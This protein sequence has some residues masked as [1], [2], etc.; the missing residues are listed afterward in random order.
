MSL[1]VDPIISNLIF[2]LGLLPHTFPNP[3][4]KHLPKPQKPLCLPFVSVVVPFRNEPADEI[5]LTMTSLL[6]Q[7]Y[8]HD[9]YEL[10]FVLEPEDLAGAR[11]VSRWLGEFSKQSVCARIVMSDGLSQMKA[12]ALNIA[13]GTATGRYCAFYD[14]GDQIDR[15]QIEKAIVLMEENSWD[16]AQARVLRTGRSIL[17]R[18]LLLD[19]CVWY[20]KYIP[21]LLRLCGGFPLS[22]EGLFIRKSVLDQ[23]SGFPEVLT[24]DALL[25]V[26]LT[27]AGRRFGLVD[28]TVSE[29]AP[30]SLLAHFRQKLRWQRGYLTCLRELFSQRMSL[31][32]KALLFL[33][34]FAPVSSGLAL[35]GWIFILAREMSHLLLEAQGVPVEATRTLYLDGLYYWSTSLAC[36]GIPLVVGSSIHSLNRAGLIREAP[37]AFC[38]PLY[39]VFAGVCAVSALFRGTT[40]WSRT[41]R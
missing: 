39:W 25:G 35:T 41:E 2:T 22:G 23:N 11:I 20:D 17:S 40:Q 7:S 16:V 27:A 26:I 10:L 6:E 36:I 32:K 1:G 33:P 28:S 34:L 38:L 29:K 31:S 21:V 13:L 15:D 18:L 14:A 19:T 24:E 9:R 12:H 4:S 3:A 8:P 30:R 37:I 5:A